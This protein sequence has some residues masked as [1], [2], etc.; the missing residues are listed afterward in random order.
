MNDEAANRGA[1]KSASGPRR[2][3]EI[4]IT[5]DTE[6]NIGGTF[7]NSSRYRPTSIEAVDCVVH[8][9]EE[10][11]GFLLRVLGEY[12]A[13]AVFFV[14][15][16]QTF[17][18]GDDR[19]GAV[20]DRIA[21]EG[22]DIQLHLHPCWLHF[23]DS[24]WRTLE[25]LNDSC[26]GRTPAELDDM[27][28]YSCDVF[29]R[30]G[31]PRPLALRTGGFHCDRNVYRAMHRGHLPFASNAALGCYRPSE[32]ELQFTSGRHFIEGVMEIPVVGYST[33][34]PLLK[35]QLRNTAITS[36]SWCEMETLLWEARESDITPFVV[37]THP[38]EFVK[39][40]DYRYRVLRRNHVNQ[41]RLVKLLDFVQRNPDS[42]TTATFA[43]HG[44]QW[45][46][47][48]AA[49]NKLLHS[50][51]SLSLARAAQNFVNDLV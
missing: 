44:Q 40:D 46:D 24:S 39:R 12:G 5:V 13:R 19:M 27:L 23:R 11:L 9:R 14:E 31:L 1:A 15:V 26:A 16:L 41:R 21:R 33:S 29:A 32:A 37:L 45:L 6:F 7:A 3:T 43:S 20:V 50:P 36:T 22:H 30:W 2:K 42:F 38:F 28:R 18:F 48:G 25:R 35:P 17:Y 49:A 51:R 47:D 10:G 34:L 4:C 8:G